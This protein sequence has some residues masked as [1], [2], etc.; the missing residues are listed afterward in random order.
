[1]PSSHLYLG[2]WKPNAPFPRLSHQL[3][4]DQGWH[5]R[6]WPEVRKQEKERSSCFPSYALAWAVAIAD[7]SRQLQIAI[8][9][10]QLQQQ[11]Q[12]QQPGCQH[13]WDCGFQHP[14]PS[15][16]LLA[17]CRAAAAV[18][19]SQHWQQW[20]SRSLSSTHGIWA[21]RHPFL[22][23]SSSLRGWHLP[24]V[25]VIQVAS[26]HLCPFSPSN[27]LASVLIQVSVFKV[28]GW[29]YLGLFLLF[30]QHIERK[31]HGIFLPGN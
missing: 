27:T 28:K 23:C 15:M 9:V 21:T 11:Q 19:A 18:V 8:I 13:R 1:M 29:K 22:F 31:K 20:C 10:A 25:I 26:F 7:H 3:V 16:G 17:S 4:P 5:W 24:G 6:P 14:E 30:W 12:E 2:T